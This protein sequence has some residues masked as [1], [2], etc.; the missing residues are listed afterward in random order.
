LGEIS[1]ETRRTGAL[2]E[3]MSQQEM[4]V[5]RTGF[6]DGMGWK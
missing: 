3:R 5:G 4:L 6:Q 1:K 2:V